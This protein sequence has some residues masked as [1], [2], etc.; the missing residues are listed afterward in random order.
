MILLSD[1][2]GT[3]ARF[4]VW[5][6]GQVAAIQVL[7]TADY[8][9]LTEA[10]LDY[11]RHAGL[12]P[13]RAIFAV[14]SAVTKDKIVFPNSP[15][16]FSQKQ[17]QADLALDRL[18]VINDFHAVALSVPLIHQDK[19][20][21]IG[22]GQATPNM[23]IGVIGPGTG[24]GVGYLLP[25][26]KG[27]WIANSGEGGHIT[28]PALNED[29]AAM[30]RHMKQ[31]GFAHVS[32]ENLA[33]GKGIEN[34]Y[35][36]LCALRGGDEKN[37]N[38]AE[39][40]RLGIAGECAICKSVMEYFCA[41]LGCVAGNLALTLGARGGVYLAGG[42]LPKIA[43]FLKASD[44]RSYFENKP[45]RQDYL[46][47]IPTYIIMQENLAFLGLSALAEQEN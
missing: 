22:A 35:R 9:N 13:A 47:D 30:I 5:R 20:V 4:G 25:D 36:A 38:A 32:A 27:G 24:L 18:K 43:D 17:L 15:W 45:P 44:F 28:A 33:S 26:A 12:K 1:I 10:V 14:G 37:L 40:S 34:M 3:H 6:D 21:Q 11:L 31:N 46:A 2:G 39:I 29:I 23:P 19:L 41:I 7:K 42:I 8:E 16:V